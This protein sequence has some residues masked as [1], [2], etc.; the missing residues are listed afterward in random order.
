LEK[1]ILAPNDIGGF[2]LAHPAVQKLHQAR[3]DILIL[4]EEKK[5]GGVDDRETE[6]EDEDWNWDGG[7]TTH[8]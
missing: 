6:Q 1:L 7:V 8:G 5:L 4:W 2:S 3:P